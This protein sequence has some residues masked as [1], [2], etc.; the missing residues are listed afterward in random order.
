MG[1]LLFNSIAMVAKSRIC[2]V[3]PLAYQ[4][5]PETPYRYATPEL[6]RRV[7]AH[8]HD[9]TTADATSPDFTV[10]PAVLNIS[11]VWSSLLYLFR[12]QVTSI[13]FIISNCQF[14]RIGGHTMPNAKMAPRPRT[15]PYPHPT[16]SGG[17]IGIFAFVL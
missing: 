5:G 1:A 13:Y 7:A 2:K 10:L 14:I 8:V 9:E 3:A 15:M 12:T 17:E 4:K 6:C 16:L 11:E